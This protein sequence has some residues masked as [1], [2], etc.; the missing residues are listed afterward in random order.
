MTRLVSNQPMVVAGARRLLRD[1][2]GTAGGTCASGDE[3]ALKPADV[4]GCEAY[5]AGARGWMGESARRGGAWRRLMPWEGHMLPAMACCDEAA[6][7][8]ADAGGREAYAA[9]ARGLVGRK[10]APAG[11]HGGVAEGVG[12]KISFV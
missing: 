8:G 9:G 5:A 1:E 12:L 6:L 11:R 4:G 2:A 10:T 7:A 3:A